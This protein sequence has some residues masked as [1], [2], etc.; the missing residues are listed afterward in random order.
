MAIV[1]FCTILIIGAFIDGYYIGIQECES[2]D[3]IVRPPDYHGNTQG[4][5][6]CMPEEEFSGGKYHNF[7]LQ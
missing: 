3:S 2:K 6:V 1:F 7:K 4:D 5:T